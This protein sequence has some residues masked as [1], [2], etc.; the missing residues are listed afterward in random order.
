MPGT[1]I[2]PTL[3]V[4]WREY[5]DAEGSHR[6]SSLQRI[7]PELHGT[8]CGVVVPR[9]GC[10]PTYVGSNPPEITQLRNIHLKSDGNLTCASKPR[11]SPTIL[12]RQSCTRSR[13]WLDERTRW[14]GSLPDYPELP[15]LLFREI[16]RSSPRLRHEKLASMNVT[17][18]VAWYLK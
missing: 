12:L 10:W 3:I 14:P 13:A 17:V 5:G 11:L 6:V 16:Q 9:A 18:W 7:V 8:Q 1:A 2:R 4:S 15:S